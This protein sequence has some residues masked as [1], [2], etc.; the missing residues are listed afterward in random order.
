[1]YVQPDRVAPVERGK[2]LVAG[3]SSRL[4]CIAGLVASFTLV[5]GAPAAVA[6]PSASSGSVD[7]AGGKAI[8]HSNRKTGSGLMSVHSSQA[9]GVVEA[10]PHVYLVLWGNQ[11]S[12]ST[13]DPD[14]AATALT[15][16]F[17]ALGGDAWDGIM[18]QYCEDVPSGTIT[19]GTAGTHISTTRDLL[20][21]VWSDNSKAAPSKTT[22]A[23]IAAEAV[24]AAAHFGNTGS[25]AA[26][27]L[28]AQYIIASASGTH[29]DS[30]P[31]GGYCAW[32]SST[33]SSYGNI[34]YTNLPYVPDLGTGA[35]TTL[36]PAQPL[37][38]YESTETHEYA[39]SVTDPF[40]S[41]GWLKGSSE[42]GDLC[43]NL[44]SRPTINGFTFDTQGLWSNTANACVDVPTS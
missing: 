33:S 40:P 10:T 42:I 5:T 9:T 36:S 38:G 22:T 25:N 18:G 7:R 12:S 34:A 20:A 30:F 41:T 6:A 15:K 28:N 23:Q 29:P 26:N 39:E 21:G 1:M 16:M 17:T 43:V 19:C 2:I 24:A 44:D 31:H 14:G 8:G 32:H 11:W 27:N 37:D 35:C 4:I 3:Q 13:G